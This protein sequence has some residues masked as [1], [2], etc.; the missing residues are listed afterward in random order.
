MRFRMR[1]EIGDGKTTPPEDVVTEINV[2]LKE[3][4]SDFALK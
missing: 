1:I 2:L 4:K 3:V